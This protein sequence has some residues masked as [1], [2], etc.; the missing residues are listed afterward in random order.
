M[1]EIANRSEVAKDLGHRR[2][3]KKK[4]TSI[5]ICGLFGKHNLKKCLIKMFLLFVN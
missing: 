3:A 1:R 4:L 2:I 5:I